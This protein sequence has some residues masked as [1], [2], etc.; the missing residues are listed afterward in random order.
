[1]VRYTL[2]YGF[3]RTL[4]KV[5]SQYHLKSQQKFSGS[6]WVNLQC[7]SPQ[8]LNRD[9][10]I[11][12]CGNFAFSNIAYYL[13]RGDCNFL[14]ATY[15]PSEARS[16]SLCK[17]YGGAYAVSNWRD[18]CEDPHIRIVFIA[19]NHSTHAEYAV[20]CIKAGKDVHIE[21]PHVVSSQQLHELISAMKNNP[22]SKV[23]LGFNRP[24]SSIFK[25][26]LYYLHKQRGPLMMNWFIVGHPIADNHW[27]L[28]Q[29][30]GGRV[31]G[32]LSH[33]T[34]LTL[35]LVGIENAFPCQV[36]AA[37]PSA[38]NSDFMVLIKFS[39]GSCVAMTFSAKGS[40]FDGVREVLNLQKGDM[41]ANISDFTTLTTDVLNR[42]KTIRPWFR[43]HGHG[44]NIL[45]SLFQSRSPEGCGESLQ[46]IVSTAQFFLTVKEAIESG[47]SKALSREDA[48]GFLE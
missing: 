25:S 13:N 17:A 46:Y 9:V 20:E 34:D 31:L 18:I 11:I 22:K 36:V 26:L 14:R 21:K 5:R 33:W 41:V 3:S 40:V 38:S 4:V 30:E 29:F 44:K 16:L 43:D 37:T 24:R 1:M 39:D 32:N 19:S 48:F 7:T 12:G 27:Y 6:Q 10:A 8:A 45:H 15:D 35:H 23:F 28:D 2:M 42:K 47:E